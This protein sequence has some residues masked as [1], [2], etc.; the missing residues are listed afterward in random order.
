[1]G[2][3]IAV[4]HNKICAVIIGR[5]EGA[6][7]ERCFRS[8]KSGNLPCVYVDSGSTDNSVALARTFEVAIVELDMQCPF[9]AARARNAGLFRLLEIAPGIEY[10][11]FIDGDCEVVPGWIEA[12]SDFLSQHG[13]V[14][15]V[16]GRC[17]ERYPERSLYNRICDIEWNTP[18][19]ETWACGGSILARV[20]A[21]TE[22]GSYRA[23]LI[24][25]EEPELCLRLQQKGL[26]IWRLP[27]DMTLHDADIRS[28]RQWWRRMIRGGHAFAEVVTI[29]YAVR[30]PWRKNLLSALMWTGLLVAIVGAVLLDWRL[31]VLAAIFPVQLVRIAR[32]QAFDW[33]TAYGYAALM[34]VGKVAETWGLLKYAAR[35]LSGGPKVLIEYK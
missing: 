4:R 14:A 32:H 28:F 18:V 26:R 27:N 15:I 23:D 3:S 8:V 2:R 6:R 10:V 31:I 34:L 16:G 30:V 13:D 7:L 1:M 22:V 21:L 12:A 19:G 33:K 35:R 25:G 20:A 29:H 11:Q 24:A 17:R 9:T 5:N